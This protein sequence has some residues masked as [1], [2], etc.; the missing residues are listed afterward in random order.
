MPIP[1][2]VKARIVLALGI[3]PPAPAVYAFVRQHTAPGALHLITHNKAVPAVQQEFKPPSAAAIRQA[4]KHYDDPA[5][6]YI[7]PRDPDWPDDLFDGLPDTLHPPLGLWI[8]GTRRL[9]DAPASVGIGG[10]EFPTEPATQLAAAVGQDVARRGHALVA[11]G[12]RGVPA[13]AVD[14]AIAVKGTLPVAP[15]VVLNCGFYGL[16]SPRLYDVYK[17]LLAVGGLIVSEYAPNCPPLRAAR[18]AADRLVAALSGCVVVVEPTLDP[19][20]S[21]I[22]TVART[23]GRPVYA[24]LGATASEPSRAIT[25][26]LESGAATVLTDAAEISAQHQE[27]AAARAVEPSPRP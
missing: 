22:A 23:L 5:F 24:A 25:T 15:I 11:S 14:A 12:F 9:T 7:T 16:E 8:G 6:R 27:L 3:R 19:E 2:E 26:M 18:Q 17:G 1:P 21:Q 4:L 20:H 10:H 13:D